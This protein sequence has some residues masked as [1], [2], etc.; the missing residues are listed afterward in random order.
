M[1]IFWVCFGILQM[2]KQL[3]SFIPFY[4]FIKS[5]LTMYLYMNDYKGAEIVYHYL[6]KHPLQL[7]IKEADKL[8]NCI[9]ETCSQPA[10]KKE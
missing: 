3:L 1:L 6:L 8:Q 7:I 2:V 4:G 5:L 9:K 10:K